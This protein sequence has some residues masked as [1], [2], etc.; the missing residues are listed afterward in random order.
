MHH[1]EILD[2][3]MSTALENKGCDLH[4]PLWTAKIL[5]ENPERIKEVHKDYFDAGA[6]A[7]ITCSYQATIPGFMKLGFDKGQAEHLI[8]LS[9]QLLLEA[10]DEWYI[11]HPEREYPLC[12]GSVGPY[13]AYLADGSEYHGHY[14]VS[15]QSLYTFHQRRIELLHEAGADCILFETQPS[16]EEV[17]VEM[18]IADAL[19]ISYWIGFSCKDDAHICEGDPIKD[20][21]KTVSEHKNCKRV[22]VNCCDPLW[23]ENLIKEIQMGCDLP[24]FVYPNSGME[25]DVKT[26]S[27][28]KPKHFISFEQLALDWYRQG[29][30]MVGG[31]C[32]T[33]AKEIRQIAKARDIYEKE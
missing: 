11:L 21:V 14:G 29:A 28:Q 23:V 12:L 19:D 16:L 8:S 5:L 17:K 33:T 3:A 27:W 6:D 4:D 20:C 25:Y 32:S 31:C 9:V 10:R 13:G 15:R 7:G 1:V 2:G 18:A 30:I 22:G 24:I 26:K